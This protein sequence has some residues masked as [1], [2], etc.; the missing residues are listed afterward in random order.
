MVKR[1]CDRCD[2]EVDDDAWQRVDVLE[3][4]DE[5]G[6]GAI[7]FN[8]DLCE[9]CADA[10]HEFMRGGTVSTKD[11]SDAGGDR[12]LAVAVAASGLPPRE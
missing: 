8:F 1:F 6:A 4:P 5:D 12:E 11:T 3:R 9:T 2:V 10:L 7:D